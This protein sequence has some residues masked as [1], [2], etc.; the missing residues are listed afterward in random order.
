MTYILSGDKT[1]G[2][3]DLDQAIMLEPAND[4]YKALRAQIAAQK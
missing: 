1:S 2:L 4:R 3:K